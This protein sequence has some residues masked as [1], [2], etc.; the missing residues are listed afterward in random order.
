MIVLF[1]KRFKKKQGPQQER[2]QDVQGGRC[3]R[4]ALPQCA[5]QA[6]AAVRAVRE[7]LVGPAPDW[8]VAQRWD[9]VLL[10]QEQ[11]LVR[12]QS[13]AQLGRGPVSMVGL[14]FNILFCRHR[15]QHL[16]IKEKVM[17][18]LERFIRFY[19]ALVGFRMFYKALENFRIFQGIL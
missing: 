3:R 17:I 1:N 11:L 18:C 8:L 2:R 13:W 12:E 9:E 10:W 4:L 19:N 7:D 6:S 14:A 15:K 5:A 16:K